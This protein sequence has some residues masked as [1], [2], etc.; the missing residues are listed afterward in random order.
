MCAPGNS[1]SALAGGQKANLPFLLAYSPTQCGWANP[2]S[3]LGRVQYW[4]RA[5]WEV[6]PC[7]VTLQVCSVAVSLNCGQ[8]LLKLTKV[9][10]ELFTKPLTLSQTMVRPLLSREGSREQHWSL[11]MGEWCGEGQPGRSI[12]KK[13][14][15]HRRGKDIS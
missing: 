7:K 12:P 13:K 11:G 14:R 3:L 4:I 5:K 1:H 15:V 2:M 8:L 9:S 6:Q 10:W